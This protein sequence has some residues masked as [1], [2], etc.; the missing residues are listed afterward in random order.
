MMKTTGLRKI[1]KSELYAAYSYLNRICEKLGSQTLW[2]PQR[3][4]L[5]SEIRQ[6]YADLNNQLHHHFF[7]HNPIQ[8]NPV[9]FCQ[10]K[11]YVARINEGRDFLL[12]SIEL[13][14]FQ[15]P[16][17]ELLGKIIN[18]VYQSCCV[19]HEL[20][21]NKESTANILPRVCLLKVNYQDCEYSS[22]EYLE[23][24][25]RDNPAPGE[26]LFFLPYKELLRSDDVSEQNNFSNVKSLFAAKKEKHRDLIGQGMLLI[27]DKKYL[28]A[29]EVFNQAKECE[30]TAEVLTLIGWCYS[31]LKDMEKAKYFCFQAIHADATYGPPYNDLGTYMLDEGNLNEALKW[32]SKAKSAPNYDNREY[33]YINA[34]R[35]YLMLKDLTSA[36][37]EFRR[38]QEMVPWQD[39]IKDTIARLQELIDRPKAVQEAFTPEKNFD[40]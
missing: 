40:S 15:L 1:F 17:L 4:L 12:A 26:L 10:W 7:D 9:D 11:E 3:Q 8:L 31:F 20:L 34:G 22:R 24:Y 2:A 39:N 14:S 18:R 29:L 5:K 36:L 30:A 33:P 35:T 19:L 27:S 13:N 32:F 28:E 6:L 21:D 25:L 16:E 38:A 23:M 37:G